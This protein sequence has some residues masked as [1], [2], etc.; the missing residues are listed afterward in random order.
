MLIAHSSNLYLYLRATF[1]CCVFLTR[2]YARRKSVN[3]CKYYSATNLT[4]IHIKSCIKLYAALL[5]KSFHEKKL[6]DIK[7]YVRIYMHVEKSQRI[8]LYKTFLVGLVTNR[9]FV[10]IQNICRGQEEIEVRSSWSNNAM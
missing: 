2:V 5:F 6:K 4:R 1:H 7:F 8:S 3:R 9:I 10:T